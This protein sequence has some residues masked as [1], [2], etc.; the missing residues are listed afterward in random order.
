MIAGVAANGSDV[1]VL[2]CKL[3]D[4]PYFNHVDLSY[5]RD[6]EVKAIK[7]RAMNSEQDRLENGLV[8]QDSNNN[9]DNIKVS[10][11]E[12]ICYLSNYKK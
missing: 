2:I 6:A 12:I 10:E 11:F 1:A 9:K 7:S 5:L 3:E 4:S 8:N